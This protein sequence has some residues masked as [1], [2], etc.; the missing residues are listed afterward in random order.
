MFITNILKNMHR[1]NLYSITYN[2]DPETEAKNL[3]LCTFFKIPY[4]NVQKSKSEEHGQKVIN[5]FF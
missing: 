4:R 3:H 2:K 5:Y 1:Y